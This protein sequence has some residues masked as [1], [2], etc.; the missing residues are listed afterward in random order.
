MG[1]EM[2]V[3]Q[4]R[5]RRLHR[6]V[7]VAVAC[8]GGTQ[9][10]LAKLLGRDPSRV[11]CDSDNPRLDYVVG[12]AEALGCSVE[13]VVE[14][15]WHGRGEFEPDG[16]QEDY[17][18]LTKQ[19]RQAYDAGAYREMVALAQR[20]LAAAQTPDEKARAYRFLAQAHRDG[21]STSHATRACERGLE[22][23]GVSRQERIA[24]Q[25]ALARVHL[26]G[27]SPAVAASLAESAL[28]AFEQNQPAE[29]AEQA[30]RA[31]AHYVR[32]D[33]F[34]RMLAYRPADA[35]GLACL[36][37][38]DLRRSAGLFTKIATAF[39]DQRAAAIAHTCAGFALEIDVELEQ[40]SPAEVVQ[41]V[42]AEV[43]R[44]DELAS[45]PTGDWLESF[46]WWCDAGLG[47]GARRLLELPNMAGFSHLLER[48]VQIGVER[49][50]WALLARTVVHRSALQD[51]L[52]RTTGL[53]L[54][55]PLHRSCL[56]LLTRV[57][58]YVPAVRDRVWELLESSRFGQ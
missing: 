15:I 41:T 47:A 32:G 35:R 42:C 45:R 13:T 14:Y 24:L 27:R 10:A 46:G 29:H 8:H 5:Q 17:S 53:R 38:A 28:A 19:A 30:F 39:D 1:C 33:A 58:D 16:S 9:T 48:A 49:S 44:L 4:D 51:H 55:L 54:E 36:A 57:A 12:L 22:V 25:L 21:G 2:T 40:R 52:A 6:L 56:S 50:D 18:A 26:D 43:A 7:D 34:R 20:M 37:R 3:A 23:D 11:Y 31:Y